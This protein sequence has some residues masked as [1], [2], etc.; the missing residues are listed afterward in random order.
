MALG[1][2]GRNV[3]DTTHDLDPN[4][5]INK[6]GQYYDPEKNG[7]DGGRKMS[8][9]AG[10]VGGESDQ[11]SQ[12]GVGK[13]LELEA[14]NSIK[15]RTCS[16]QKVASF[17]LSPLSSDVLE[18]CEKLQRR[19]AGNAGNPPFALVVLINCLEPMSVSMS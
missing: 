12:W 9:I 17:H 4:S 2:K 13:Q 19:H 1:K 18:P 8:R 16:W 6:K 11:D 10:L 3:D 14:T 15:Y 5:T 7:K